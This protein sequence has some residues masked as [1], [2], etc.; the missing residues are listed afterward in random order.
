MSFKEYPKWVEGVLVSDAGEEKIVAGKV[1]KTKPA[2]QHTQKV[3]KYEPAE[4]PKWVNGVIVND[5]EEEKAAKP[6]RRRKAK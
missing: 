3:E 1:T 6:T 5:A 2:K 4:Y